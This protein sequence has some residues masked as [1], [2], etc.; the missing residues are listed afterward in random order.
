M[1]VRPTIFQAEVTAIIE[2]A[3][4]NLQ[5]QRL[6]RYKQSGSTKDQWI[7]VKASLELICHG[8]MSGNIK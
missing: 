2:C 3:W 7:Q 4:E 6:Y 5:M 1:G 8:V